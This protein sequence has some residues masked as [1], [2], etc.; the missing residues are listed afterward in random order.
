MEIS[1]F[2]V[3][4]ET[5]DPALAKD[6]KA[7]VEQQL[8]SQAPVVKQSM[9]KE[10][11]KILEDFLQGDYCLRGGQGWWKYEFCYGKHVKQYHEF[12]QGNAHL[13]TNQL[14]KK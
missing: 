5:T 2:K 4:I 10:T 13:M 8:K 14:D 1:V 9:N 7:K 11:R 6:I 3:K 12:T